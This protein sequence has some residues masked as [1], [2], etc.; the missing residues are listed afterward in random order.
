MG[1]S[2]RGSKAAHIIVTKKEREKEYHFH[3]KDIPISPHLLNFILP[4]NSP[5]KRIHQWVNPLEKSEPS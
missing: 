1:E 3:F 4:P 5:L 2:M